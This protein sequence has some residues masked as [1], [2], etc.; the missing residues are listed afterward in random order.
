MISKSGVLSKYN[1]EFSDSPANAFMQLDFCSISLFGSKST[2]LCSNGSQ[3]WAN[4]RGF[5]LLISMVDDFILTYLLWGW[6]CWCS[7]R[8]GLPITVQAPPT[9]FRCSAGFGVSAACPRVYERKQLFKASD[10]SVL[11]CQNHSKTYAT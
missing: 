1:M 4:V 5:V 2:I 10:L 8:W 7:G 9:G 11:K 3:L 6:H